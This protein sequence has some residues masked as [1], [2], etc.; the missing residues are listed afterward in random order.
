MRNSSPIMTIHIYRSLDAANV[1]STPSTKQRP[2]SLFRLLTLLPG[3]KDDNICCNL[4][5][6]SLD[7]APQYEALSYTWGSPSREHRVTC[8]GSILRITKTLQDALV[9]LRYPKEVRTLWIDQLC[10]NQE[11]I[12]ERNTQVKIMHLIY[13]GAAR[14]VV[15]LGTGV[16]S[17]SDIKL[18]WRALMADLRSVHTSGKGKTLK[19]YSRLLSH[20]YFQRVWV[21]QEIRMS[22]RTRIVVY[23]RDKPMS[24]DKI[25]SA[26][27]L[28]GS[29]ETGR[30][31][32]LLQL[33]PSVR[34]H[35]M[36]IARWTTIPSTN[37]TFVTNFDEYI[38]S[39]R[40]S[41]FLNS[42]P[43]IL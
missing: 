18:G 43:F 42:M 23:Y 20:P 34:R 38:E 7:H 29:H 25:T 17:Y 12:E 19:E 28:L 37:A 9:C 36:I 22:V 6:C 21:L 40:R 41:L 4:T 16:A 10:I 32:Q 27:I 39:A 3:D 30:R 26:G 11:D 5:H 31:Y 33:R 1:P 2:Q 8:N 14:T 13:K 35:E 24:W 15:Y